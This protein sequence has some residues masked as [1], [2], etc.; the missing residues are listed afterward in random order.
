MTIRVRNRLI[1]ILFVLTIANLLLGCGFLLLQAVKGLLQAPEEPVRTFRLFSNVLNY[2][3]AATVAGIMFFFF[4]VP[5]AVIFLFFCFEKT[6]S[7]EVMFFLGFLLGCICEESRL[8]ICAGGL[9]QTI[10]ATLIFVGRLTVM[11]RLL[12]PL[13]LLFASLLNGNSQRQNTE[14]NFLILILISIII[15]KSFPLNTTYTTTTCTVLWSYRP[16]FTMSRALVFIATIITLL[17]PVL[18]T[19]SQEGKKTLISY[20]FMINGYFIL[21]NADNFVFLILGMLLL[22]TGTFFYLKSV[23]STYLWK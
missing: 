18:Q 16:L 1:L 13:S 2:S 23:H 8:L 7:I 4:Y 22:S 21:C 3:F 11:G 19:K 5:A 6:Q 15:G 12:A 10:S 17:L 14:R 9:W 20:A